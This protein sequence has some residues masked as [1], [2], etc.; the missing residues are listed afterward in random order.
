MID[1]N[2]CDQQQVSALLRIKETG[3]KAL[4]N[5]FEGEAEKAKARLVIATD[6]VSIHRLQ[7]RAEAFEDLLAAV[8]DAP[9]GGNRS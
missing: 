9:K 6:T 5:L 7:G 1:L 3:D 8:E 2:L 4:L